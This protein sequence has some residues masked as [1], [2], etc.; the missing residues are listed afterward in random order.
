MAGWGV[1]TP[2]HYAGTDQGVDF[3]GAGK[4]PALD[5]LTVTSV[6]RVGIIEGGS[7]PLV[8]FRFDAGPYAGR[9]GYVMENFTPTVRVGQKLK[10]GQ[11]I[12]TAT[13][14]Y[15]YIEVGFASDASGTPA[16]PLYPNP[17]GAKPEGAQMWAYIQSLA[18]GGAPPPANGNGGLPA[19]SGVSPET[20]PVGLFGSPVGTT[21]ALAI[22]L[23]FAATGVAL[24][25]LALLLWSKATTRRTL[26]AGAA[27]FL[28]GES[29]ARSNSSSSSSSSPPSSRRARPRR[30]GSSVDVSEGASRREAIRERA[31]RAQ[32]SDEIP[33]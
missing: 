22:R 8:G 12:G 15:P 31:A 3:T 29:R 6:R 5:E 30:A 16:A 11:T 23:V 32:P 9:Y 33:F 26:V 13:G 27:G 28:A 24:I 17:H 2:S 20:Q 19:G 14:S 7:Y 1:L 4:I 25:V 18:S 21:E 10:R